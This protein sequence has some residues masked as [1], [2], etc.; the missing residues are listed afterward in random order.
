[1]SQAILDECEA[2]GCGVPVAWALGSLFRLW[3]LGILGD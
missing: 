1:M 2:A 3:G